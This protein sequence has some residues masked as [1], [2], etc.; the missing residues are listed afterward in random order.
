MITGRYIARYMA[1]VVEEKGKTGLE[2][3]VPDLGK[4]SALGSQNTASEHLRK[5]L[6]SE[7]LRSSPMLRRLLEYIGT[8]S[9][10]GRGSELKEFTIGVEAL[11]R[12]DDFD[13]K[14]DTIVRVQIHRLREKLSRYYL[15]EGGEDDLLITIPRGHYSAEF[16]T[17]EVAGQPITVTSTEPSGRLST[18]KN[19]ADPSYQILDFARFLLA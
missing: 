3:S 16:I 12:S 6:Q 1:A 9:L 11:D 2:E 15:E 13:P 8:R 18:L 4:D 19:Q 5:V 17:A 10:D 7:T 14:V